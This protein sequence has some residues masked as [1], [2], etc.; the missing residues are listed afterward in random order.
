MGQVK[1]NWNPVEGLEQIEREKIRTNDVVVVR[2][3]KYDPLDRDF[4]WV[5]GYSEYVKYFDYPESASFFVVE[6]AE[7]AE[8]LKQ[9]T[10]VT[11]EAKR[12]E[13][14]IAP[15]EFLRYAGPSQFGRAWVDTRNGE[16]YEWYEVLDEVKPETLHVKEPG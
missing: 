12:G 14:E 8:P 1:D 16:S 5:Y 3:K 13:F 6:R 11:G 15:R 4:D 9:G 10:I 2:V 7:I